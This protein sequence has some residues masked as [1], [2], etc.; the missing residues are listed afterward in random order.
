MKKL[1]FKE[2]LEIVRN[3]IRETLSGNAAFALL[4]YSLLH[5]FPIKTFAD[6]FVTT[7][8]FIAIIAVVIWL[9][10]IIYVYFCELFRS[11]WIAVWFILW[12]VV[13]N[14]TIGFVIY[15]KLAPV[16]SLMK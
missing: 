3:I 9:F 6:L 15:D 11:H 14:L 12:S 8:L 5:S 4:V 7:L 1:S 10:L 13:I 16:I 2:K